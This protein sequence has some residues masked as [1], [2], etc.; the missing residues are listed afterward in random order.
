MLPQSWIQLALEELHDDI[1]AGHMGTE[2]TFE[3]IR[4]G[5]YW[6][7][8]YLDVKHWCENCE[9]CLARKGNAYES[10][11]SLI[12]MPVQGRHFEEI[13]IDFLEIKQP[14]TRGNCYIMVVQDYF[15]KW[16]E[17]YPM[18]DINAD[19]RARLLV[20]EWVSC[21]G[22]PVSINLEQG[23]QLELELFKE[24]CKILETK[25]RRL[26]S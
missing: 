24:L 17:G 25:K 22:C 13:A 14:T 21:F 12:N 16:I 15:T 6:P 26:S 20:N 10:K 2:R 7:S 19:K 11:A 3:S 1:L 4:L 5:Y 18:K 23:S 9:E 8:Y